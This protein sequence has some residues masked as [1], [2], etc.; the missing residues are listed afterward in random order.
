MIMLISRLSK[1]NLWINGFIFSLFIIWTG[2]QTDSIEVP[3]V[4]GIEVEV[5]FSRFEQ[6]LMSLDTNDIALAL[7]ELYKK[8]PDFAPVY[9]QQVLQMNP[10]LLNSGR[11]QEVVKGLIQFPSVQALSDTVQLVYGNI[12]DLTQ[13]FEQAFKYYK[14][15]F[16]GNPTP[17]LISYISEYNVGVF[18]LEKDLIGV[19][20]D[21]FLGPAYSRYDINYFPRYIRRTMTKEHIVPK[22]IE[23][24]SYE[25]LGGQPNSTMLEQMI[26]NGKALYIAKQVQPFVADSLILGYTGD[27]LKWVEENERQMWAFF[28]KEELL[29]ETKISEFRKYVDYSPNAPGMPPEAPGRTANWIGWQIIQQ[30]MERHPETSLQQ[31]I[32]QKDA[33]YLLNHSRYK[34]GR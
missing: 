30:Y 20:L 21:F 5:E 3:D 9:F 13:E 31:L 26:Y 34:P 27:Q 33:Q 11:F 8:Y 2:C 17:R 1:Q 24:L 19:G 4:S 10:Q 12:D 16:P 25:L 18:T 23:A 6:E 32:D 14:H 7:D 15:Y 29:Y 22:A 28:L